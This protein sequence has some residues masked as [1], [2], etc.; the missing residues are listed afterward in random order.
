M[1]VKYVR[2]GFTIVELLIVIVI[3]GILAAITI[4]AFNGV[5]DRANLAAAQSAVAQ[6]SKKILAASFDNADNYPVAA[7]ISGIDN[8]SAIGI[9]N[10]GD[11]TYQYSSNNSVNPRTFCL[12]ATKDTRSSFFS[13]TGS[14]TTG[15]CPGHGSGGVAP[16]TNLLTNTSVESSTNNL[17][18]IG[19]VSDRTIARTAVSDAYNGG[20]VL[21]ITAGPS[22]GIAGYGSSS[23]TV[24]IGRYTGSVWLRSNV[25]MSANP[26]FEG[27]AARTNVTN[28]GR[29]LVAGQWAQVWQTVEVTTSGTLKIGFLSG[30]IVAQGQYVE[31]DGFMLTSGSTNYNFANGA[32]SNWVWNGAIDA[33]SSTGSPL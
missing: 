6:A 23:P 17:Q 28:Q 29:S 33:S 26:Y 11:T 12:T 31:I 27:S 10:S 5:Q 4:V 9:T 25:A 24:P 21:R 30:N 13:S 15:S 32:S 14:P 19:S 20:Y 3:I 8:L 2:T 1:S 16:I 22:G 7:G 18:N